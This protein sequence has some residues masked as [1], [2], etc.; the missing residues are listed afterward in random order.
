[1]SRVKLGARRMELGKS[2]GCTILSTIWRLNPVDL[3]LEQH[4]RIEYRHTLT[5]AEPIREQ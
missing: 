5:I 1:M 3:L 4:L 2:G